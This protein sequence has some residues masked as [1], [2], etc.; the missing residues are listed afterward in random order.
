[1]Q[2]ISEF[3]KRIQGNYAREIMVRQ[4]VR[5]AVLKHT[6]ADLPIASIIFKSTTVML[7]NISHSARSAIYV[8][9]PA[10]LKDISEKQ[11]IRI[12]KDIR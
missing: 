2:G 3:F 6:G 1:M 12:I 5:E 10:I 8:K 9:K 4:A 7:K 11:N